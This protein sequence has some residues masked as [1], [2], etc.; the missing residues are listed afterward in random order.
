MSS[1]QRPGRS[2]SMQEPRRGSPKRVGPSKAC[3]I[4]SVTAYAARVWEAIDTPLSLS[5][6]L[7]ARN[8]EWKQLVSKS[9]S[10]SHYSDSHSFY[11]DYQA[12]KLMSKCPGLPTGIDTEL[13]AKR[14][15]IECEVACQT[16]NGTFSSSAFPPLGGRVLSIIDRARTIISGILGVVPDL[17]S[18]DYEFGP[19]A[20]FQVRGDTSVYQKIH[21]TPECT[22]TL[23]PLLPDFLGYFPGWFSSREAQV[24]IV[25]GSE[26]SFVPKDAKT[27]RPIC[28]EPTLNGLGQKGIG[29]FLK[30]RLLRWGI[31][32]RD[33]TINQ[34]LASAAFDDGFATVDFSSA[35]DT[36]A[37]NLVWSLLPI[38]WAELLDHFRCP[39]YHCEGQWYN[40]QKFSS[41]G[42]AYTFELET[43]I[44]FALAHATM[45]ELGIPVRVG[46]NVHVYGDDV[47]IPREAF[48]TYSKV[49]AVCG[50]TVNQDKSFSDGSFF[51]SCGADSFQG[52]LVTPF[53]QKNDLTTPEAVYLAANNLVRMAE[54][55]TDLAGAN[56]PRPHE[57]RAAVVRCA[58]LAGVHRWVIDHLRAA[59]R[60][61]GPAQVTSSISVRR[62]ELG[63]TH[64]WCPWD[65]ATP[66]IGTFGYRYRMVQ[67]K[68]TKVVPFAWLADWDSYEA[69]EYPSSG[70]ALYLAKGI[71]PPLNGWLTDDVP[72]EGNVTGY[73]LR[74]TVERKRITAW[75]RDW[76]FP[77][78]CWGVFYTR[79]HHGK[80]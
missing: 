49:A 46:R 16:T 41:M 21:V 8:G 60:V 13:V 29:A 68:P 25:Q 80:A 35:S 1:R 77:W 54:R 52:Q 36:I 67:C 40:F 56:S 33:Q 55:L 24:T 72:W 70:Y 44:F 59:W 6:Y 27:D 20:T 58:S 65:F 14:K 22:R 64:L 34:R 30:R 39:R 66:R 2:A 74:S 50:F 11:L 51:E 53:R 7:L 79:T 69:K 5:C 18:L 48:I 9:V 43:L 26:L 42:N 10:P 31:D 71:K 37:Y 73:A 28:I 63:D 19:G 3:S 62:P 76:S 15:F 75:A 12:V 78:S 4:V 38:D 23:L 47:I 32:L 45:D 57:K 61:Y 17:E